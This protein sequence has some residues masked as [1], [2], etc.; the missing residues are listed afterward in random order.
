MRIPVLISVLAAG[1]WSSE[2][3]PTPSLEP[4]PTVPVPSAL[5]TQ[6]SAMFGELPTRAAA[7]ADNPITDA[8]VSLGRMLFHDARLSATDTIS[9]NNCHDLSRFG[10]DGEATSPGHDGTRGDRN[11]PSVYNAALHATQF[12]DGRAA[13]VEAQATGPITNPVEMGMPDGD[14]VVAKLEA[15]DG[16]G[17][18][19]AAAF[20]DQP[21]PITFDNVG[22][23]IG[24]FERTLLTP[25]PFDRWLAGD[26]HAMTEDQVAG[27]QTYVQTGCASCH[28]GTAFGGQQFMKLGQIEPYET[29]DEGRAKVTGKDVDKF[30]F[31]VPS[32]RNI[33]H[34]GPYLHDGSVPTLEEMVRLMAKHQLGRDLSEEQVT[35]IVA[36][37]NGLTGEIPQGAR[38]KPGLPGTG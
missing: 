21:D 16:Y 28:M 20:P 18:L 11:S 32:L 4:A 30:F 13:D 26:D 8:K 22:R 6:A 2:P 7:K 17:A 23:A 9:C 31:K 10:V 24:A 27:L 1:C 3:P 33:A 38:S 35:Q 5:R 37:L 12:W 36:F 14:S 19:F 29:E 25:A 15:I 34:T